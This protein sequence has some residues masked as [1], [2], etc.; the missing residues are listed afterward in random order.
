[1]FIMPTTS[2]NIGSM[3]LS[4]LKSPTT[5]PSMDWTKYELFDLLKR[6]DK[7]CKYKFEVEKNKCIVDCITILKMFL[8]F[9]FLYGFILTC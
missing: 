1:M 6:I 5:I 4:L 2:V 7:F 9:I 8:N 3:Y